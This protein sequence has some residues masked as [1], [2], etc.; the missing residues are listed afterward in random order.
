MSTGFDNVRFS[1]PAVI[2]GQLEWTIFDNVG[3]DLT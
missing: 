3:P 2:T 1:D